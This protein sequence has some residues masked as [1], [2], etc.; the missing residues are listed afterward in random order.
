MNNV[1][2]PERIITLLDIQISRYS[3]LGYQYVPDTFK[4]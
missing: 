1:L 4:K 2:R 3:R